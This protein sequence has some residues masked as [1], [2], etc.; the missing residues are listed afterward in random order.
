MTEIVPTQSPFDAIKRLDEHGE[1]WSARELMAHFGY[2]RWPDVKDGVG[3]ALVSISNELGVSAAQKHIEATHKMVSL[4]RGAQREI[5]DYRL[6][7][8]GAYI[9]AMNCDPRKPEIAAAQ[10]YFAV[11]TRE[12]EI[13]AKTPGDDLDVLQGI[14]DAIRADRHRL[15]I[16]EAKLHAIEGQH[17]WFT[18]LG[19]A[20]L[21]D[22]PTDRRFLAKVGSRAARMLRARGQEPVPRQ[23]ATFGSVNTYPAD[24]LAE[25]FEAVKR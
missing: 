6:T 10:T 5:D 9:W 17:D 21:H 14:I 25:A 3:R 11:K 13:A 19:Y 8:Y 24:L 7:R 16:V 20:K 12:A 15:N 18:C 2:A 4:G 23:D 22:Y 1:H